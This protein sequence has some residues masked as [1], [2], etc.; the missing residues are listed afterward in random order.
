MERV[1]K[2]V[3]RSPGLLL[4]RRGSILDDEVSKPKLIWLMILLPAIQIWK[5]IDGLF[6]AG[7]YTLFIC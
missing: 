6:D 2:A 5:D 7:I 3:K 1:F 4:D